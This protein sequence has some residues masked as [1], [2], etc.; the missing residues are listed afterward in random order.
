M[1]T[2]GFPTVTAG[3]VIK[4]AFVE[5][6]EPSDLENKVNAA[7]AALAAENF[8]LAPMITLSGGGDGH[9]FVVNIV[10][11]KVGANVVIQGQLIPSTGPFGCRAFCYF[12]SDSEALVPACDQA[13]ARLIASTLPFIDSQIAGASQGTRFMGMLLGNPFLG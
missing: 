8:T 2:F 11:A 10:G 4:H 5:S 9:V 6:A 3:G 13:M 12:A 7:L 1:S